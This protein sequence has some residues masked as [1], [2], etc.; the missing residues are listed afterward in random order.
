M[1]WKMLLKI[2]NCKMKILRI[3]IID[4]VMNYARRIILT[5]EDGNK[6]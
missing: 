6:N 4:K 2:G 5:F 1:I 3:E